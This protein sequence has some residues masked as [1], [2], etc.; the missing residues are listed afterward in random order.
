MRR[1]RLGRYFSTNPLIAMSV[2]AASATMV[3]LASPDPTAQTAP[4]AADATTPR[5][6]SAPSRELGSGYASS[7][8]AIV[9]ATGDAEGLHILSARESDG[10]SVYEIARLNRKELSDVGPWTGYVCTT[11]SGNCAAAVYA[12]S[13]W[14]NEPGAYE[15]GAFAAVIRLSTARSPRFPTGYN[16]RTTRRA[17]ERATR[18]HSPPARPP[19]G[20][21]ARRR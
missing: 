6:F 12:P 5:L 16:W 17:A 2:V 15:N 19:T 1:R 9:Q 7:P 13:A 11:G 21:P 18:W 14:S 10:F 3:P 4:A 8:D 20:P